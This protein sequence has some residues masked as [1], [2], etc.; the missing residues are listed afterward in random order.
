MLAYHNDHGHCLLCTLP[1]VEPGWEDRLVVEHDHFQVFVP[2][3]AESE[4]EMWI[5]PRRHQAEFGETTRSER[6]ALA[7][8]VGDALRRLRDRAGNPPYN[9]MIHSPRRSR[10][11]SQAFHWFL[12]IRPRKAQS[13]GFE[14]ASGIAINASS[15]ERDARIL[16]GEEEAG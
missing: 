9:L 2:W 6:H 10:S 3:A 5:V 12:Q 13:A 11:G 16:R 7:D 8:A 14:L 4:C 15:P 1:E